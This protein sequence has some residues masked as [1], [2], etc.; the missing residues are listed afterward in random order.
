MRK[1]KRSIDKD[2]L[3]ILLEF[4]M[5]RYSISDNFALSTV[6]NPS[7]AYLSLPKYFNLNK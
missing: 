1:R 3:F 4:G 5:R 7:I 6:V 2:N